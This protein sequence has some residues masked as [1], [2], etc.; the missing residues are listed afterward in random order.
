MCVCVCVCV[1]VGMIFFLVGPKR[2]ESK[3][4]KMDTQ[5]FHNEYIHTYTYT[6]NQREQRKNL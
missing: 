6:M 1:C 2:E 3:Y 5:I 4:F